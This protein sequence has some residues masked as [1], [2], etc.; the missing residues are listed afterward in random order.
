M[1]CEYGGL[2]CD[3][4]LLCTSPEF[5][6]YISTLPLFVFKSMDLSRLHQTP[7]VA[8]NWCIAAQS[9][10]RILVM[11]RKLLYAYWEEKDSLDHYFI[12]HMFFAMAARKYA[13]DWNAVPMF[14]NHSPHT[15]MFE[16][17]DDFSEERWEQ[18]MKMSDLH[19]L[20]HHL[21]HNEPKNTFY[22]H[23]ISKYYP[24]GGETI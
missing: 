23:I 18:I 20:N 4:T 24:E 6:G 10:Q 22:D 16:L 9:N 5:P 11:T 3:A 7:S 15:L 17:E 8:S 13:D 19:K 12:F 2:W 14:N 21:V 1:L